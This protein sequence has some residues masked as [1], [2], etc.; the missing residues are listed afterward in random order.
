M[1]KIETSIH[2]MTG[3]NYASVAL[4]TNTAIV[5]YDPDDVGVRDIIENIKVNRRLQYA[6]D[7]ALLACNEERVAQEVIDEEGIFP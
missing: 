5:D 7:Y 6:F 3:V 1:H 2:D 4:A